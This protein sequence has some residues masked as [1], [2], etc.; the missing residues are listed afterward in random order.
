MPLIENAFK[1]A[2]DAT[3]FELTDYN[4]PLLRRMQV[5]APGTYHHS[6]MVANWLKMLHWKLKQTQLFAGHVP[7]FMTLGKWF[8]P[9]ILP[10]TKEILATL[11]IARIRP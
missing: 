3:L 1:V 4:H 11:T 9:I 7:C 8:N 2:T 5:E 10:K 6:L